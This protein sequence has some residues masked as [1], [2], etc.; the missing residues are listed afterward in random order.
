MSCAS[1]EILRAGRSKITGL[2]SRSL[3]PKISTTLSKTVTTGV[4]GGGITHRM[5]ENRRSG[6]SG[7][8]L[9]SIEDFEEKFRRAF[10]RDMTAEE[11]HF[12]RLTNVLLD[13]DE[14]EE[15]AEGQC[16]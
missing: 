10:G 3:F 11:R 7:R 13:D 8:P 2:Q 16:A 14:G 9:P 12:F 5:P 1:R 6:R 4:S 15:R